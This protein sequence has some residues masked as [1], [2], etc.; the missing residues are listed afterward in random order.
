[1]IIL[2]AVKSDYLYWDFSC[3]M[4]KSQYDIA[5]MLAFWTITEVQCYFILFCSCLDGY[6]KNIAGF[7]AQEKWWQVEINQ[8][9]WVAKFLLLC[10]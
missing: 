2:V 3:I 6:D 9:C 5:H 8:S 1:M 7:I 10:Y 4:G